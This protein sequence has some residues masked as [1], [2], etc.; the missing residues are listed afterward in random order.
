MAT[1]GPNSITIAVLAERID[2]QTKRVDKM[3]DAV[4]KLTNAVNHRNELIE[5]RL[6]KAEE[7]DKWML[8]VCG[9]VVTVSM[10]VAVVVNVLNTV[11]S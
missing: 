1:R 10:L 2:A 3:E 7:F 6:T 11:L 9:A 5:N 8:R 4:E